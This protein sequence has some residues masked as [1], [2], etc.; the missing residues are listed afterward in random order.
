MKKLLL[1]LVFISYCTI[2]LSAATI[3][4]E[5]PL[6]MRQ[7]AC[8]DYEKEKY[9][10]KNNK[11]NWAD[12]ADDMYVVGNRNGASEVEEEEDDDNDDNDT[13]DIFSTGVVIQDID[14]LNLTEIDEVLFKKMQSEF[15][16]Y[17]QKVN[18]ATDMYF[19][20]RDSKWILRDSKWILHMCKYV[21][22]GLSEEGG[23]QGANEKGSNKFINDTANKITKNLGDSLRKGACNYIMC[24]TIEELVRIAEIEN[25]FILF[26]VDLDTFKEAIHLE[27]EVASLYKNMFKFFKDRA[28]M[29]GGDY[30]QNTKELL[31][32]AQLG[33]N[34]Y[35]ETWKE[36]AQFSQHS[37]ELD[38]KGQLNPKTEMLAQIKILEV[39]MF[40]IADRTKVKREVSKLLKKN[41]ANRAA[42]K[43]LKHNTKRPTRKQRAI[44]YLE[45]NAMTADKA[46]KW[47]RKY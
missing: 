29:V 17:V 47:I 18:W 19:T 4:T 38:S 46:G 39:A 25:P 5:G 21:C 7:T 23:Y 45:N 40:H 42:V 10:R 11:R 31:R 22:G 2:P 15:L 6:D 13:T 3:S 35:F 1:L 32:I 43:N 27:P 30:N 41:P 9:D 8:G 33:K 26:A 24:L 20:P 37:K 14:S 16:T 34:S 12:T 28:T 44:D 36:L